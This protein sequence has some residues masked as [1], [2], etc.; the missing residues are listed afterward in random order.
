MP[1]MSLKSTVRSAIIGVVVCCVLMTFVTA[2]AYFSLK[3][4]LD[5]AAYARSVDA[6]VTKLDL[7]TSELLMR[8]SERVIL[9]LKRQ[10]AQL[11]VQLAGPPRFNNR[12]DIIAV[13]LARRVAKTKVLIEQLETSFGAA[14]QSSDFTKEARD[15]L[16][17]S[18]IA[19]SGNL[20]S[21]ALEML[22][23]VSDDT[24]STQ[25]IVI[26]GIGGGILAIIIGGG[27]FLS[28]LSHSLLTR[29]LRLRSVIQEIGGGISPRTFPRRPMMRW[30]MSSASWII[31]G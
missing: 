8:W 19:E 15:I 4:M 12:A 11:A 31:C 3:A 13:E 10:H 28:L 17:G 22:D 14:A 18:L 21:R 9:Q 24:A 25:R 20:H 16:F 29:I 1:A 23:I 2:N 30:A 5:Q 6:N 27:L 7:L 26:T